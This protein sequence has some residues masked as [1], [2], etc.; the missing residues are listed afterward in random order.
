LVWPCVLPAHASLSN[1]NI[2]ADLRVTWGDGG[3][4]RQGH[5]A[6]LT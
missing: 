3:W 6:V 5:S 2:A 1:H 4:S